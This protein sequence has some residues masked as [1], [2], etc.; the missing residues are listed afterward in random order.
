MQSRSHTD[1]LLRVARLLTLDGELICRLDALDIVD[2]VEM[3]SPFSAII[4]EDAGVVVRIGFVLIE[5]DN[6][7][8]YPGEI[9]HAEVIP[10]S[11][12]PVVRITGVVGPT[13]SAG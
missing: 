5:E 4:P 7:S 6:G 11:F 1:T 13:R 12:G 3:G 8:R 10:D 2:S 9:E